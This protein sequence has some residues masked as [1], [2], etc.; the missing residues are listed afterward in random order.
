MKYYYC[1]Y[2]SIS[3]LV[4]LPNDHLSWFFS[5]IYTHKETKWNSLPV[6]F[7]VSAPRAFTHVHI[8]TFNY[9]S[10]SNS[11][12]DTEWMRCVLY[13]VLAPKMNAE[14]YSGTLLLFS[15]LF[16][17]IF[18]LFSHLLSCPSASWLLLL[19]LI[20]F[21]FLFGTQQQ[22]WLR[23]CF[24]WPRHWMRECLV[25]QTF[26]WLFWLG[27]LA[28]WMGPWLTTKWRRLLCGR[29]NVWL[30]DWATAR[31]TDW[32]ARPL[33]YWINEYLSGEL[34]GYQTV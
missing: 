30:G 19:A 34:N 9:I 8:H 32:L 23:S 6:W 17:L 1:V 16:I 7:C 3:S 15:F 20:F 12:P 11:Q 14:L 22:C 4:C 21:F 31:A 24:G 27:F 26:G 10:I 18:C 33:V 28:G 13:H 2:C 29:Q 5:F 25:R